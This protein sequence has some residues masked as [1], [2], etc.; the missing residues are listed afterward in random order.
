MKDILGALLNTKEASRPIHLQ[1]VP[2]DKLD[3]RD[4]LGSLPLHSRHLILLID[5]MILTKK[6]E[7]GIG[8]ILRIFI[9]SLKNKIPE[10]TRSTAYYISNDWCIYK[11]S[12]QYLNT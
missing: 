9:F 6:S 12:T 11:K 8:I 1:L 2:L 10:I 4:K 7:D 5:K 3:E